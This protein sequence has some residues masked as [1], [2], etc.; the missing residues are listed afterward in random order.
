MLSNGTGIIAIVGPTCT[1]KSAL[2]QIFADEFG[3]EIINADSMQVYKH[4]NIGTAKPD[5]SALGKTPHH[6][7]DIVEP[8]D[9]FNA[10]M[11]VDRA[12]AAI[13][14]VTGRRR[15]PILVGGTG[16]YLRALT[17]GLFKAPTEGALRESLRR[18]YE[19]DPLAFYEE[20]KAVDHAYAMRISFKD[21]I[22]VVRA[23]E[24]YRLT[25]TSMSGLEEAHG[26]R[27]PRYETLKLGL[28]GDREELYRRI[29]RRV[30]EMLEQGWVDEVSAILSMGYDETSKPF[31][32]I[33]YREILLYIRGI[34]PYGDMVE[35]IKKNTRHYAK[36]QLTWFAKEKDVNWYRYPEETGAMREKAAEFLGS[37]N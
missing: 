27:E 14:E 9:D 4:F 29:N 7:I 3:G 12:D 2:S 33:G 25:G 8:R 1:G 28:T 26:F 19:K 35:D 36:R 37:W 15:V 24:V 21:K 6:L 32:S 17:Y 34:I 10:A 5:A 11:F 23:M 20:L 31:T 30:E 18:D 22:R 16:L 13:S